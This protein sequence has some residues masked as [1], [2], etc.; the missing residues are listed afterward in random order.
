MNQMTTG[1][2]NDFE[3]ATELARKMTT[4]F[5]MTNEMGPVIYG[6]NDTEVFLGRS[7]T[8][9]K[10]ISEDT[11]RKIDETVRGILEKQYNLA[12]Q[13]LMDN[14]DKV[15]AMTKMLLEKETINMKEIQLIM[16]PVSV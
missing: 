2:S 8:T 12:K 15:E 11:L 9:H 16:N 5:G 1:A 10:S 3:R 6:E 13:L 4:R 7:V 14:R